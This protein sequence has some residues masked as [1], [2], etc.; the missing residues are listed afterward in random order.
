MKVTIKLLCLLLVFSI[1][2][3]FTGCLSLT[4]EVKKAHLYN[5]KF[6]SCISRGDFEEA[7]KYLHPHFLE[8]IGS[9]ADHLAKFES[10][11]V[12]FSKGVYIKFLNG[13]GKSSTVLLSTGYTYKGNKFTYD[14]LIGNERISCEISIG[15]NK[16]GYGIYDIRLT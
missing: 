7:E 14:V 9:L 5:E 3:S 4:D 10:E 15:E 12:D 2:L 11:T 16:D 1:C 13:W 8:E 6:F